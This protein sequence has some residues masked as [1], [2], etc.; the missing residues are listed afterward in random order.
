LLCERGFGATRLRVLEQLGAPQERVRDSHAESFALA[1]IDDLNIVALE[2]VAAPGALSIPLRA[3]LPDSAFENDG[4]LTKQDIRAVTL[5]ALAPHPGQLLWDVGAGAGSIGIEWM[6]SHP[7][8]R[9]IAIERDPV[10]AAR[11]RRNASALGVP[12]LQVVEAA[13]PHGLAA[14]ARPDVI[15]VGGGGGDVAIFEA[16]WRALESGGRLVVNSVSLQTEALLLRLHEVH[17]GELRRLSVDSV[18]KLG[19]MSGWR[20]AMPVMQWRIDKP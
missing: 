2:L 18:V 1:D 20:P 6:L 17:G 16:C 4:Q 8:C 5:S 13:A 19:T 10:R 3:S 14:L 7:S 12:T 9:A 11:I 15:F